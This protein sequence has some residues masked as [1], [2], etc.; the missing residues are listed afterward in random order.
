MGGRAAIYARFSSHNQRGESIEI[1]VE[2]SRAYCAENDLRVVATYCDFAQTGTNTDRAEFQRMMA[3]AKRG[4]FDFV[5]IYKV[6][7]IMR[8]RDEMAMARIMLRRCRVEILYAGED[9]SDGSAGVL[10]LGMLE[11]LAEYESALDGERIRDGIQKNA[12]RCMANGCVRYGWDI[13][14]GRYVV[15]EEE[16]AA[17]RLGVRMVLSG[18]S[19]ADVV[20]AWEPYRTK[21]GGKWRFQTVRRILMRR[22]NGGEYR[23]AGVVVPGGMPAIVPMD[24]EERVIRMLEDSHRPRAKTEAWD[25]PLTG[26]LYDGRDGGLMTGTSGTGKSGR[27]YHYYRCRSCGR[28][29]RGRRRARGPGQRRQPRAHRSHAGRR[30]GGARRREALERDHKGRAGQDRDGVLQHMGGHRVGHRAA[31]RQGAHRR[32]EA[33]AGA[34][35]G[36]AAHGRG[37]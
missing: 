18:K 13:V 5:V 27:P 33:A 29:A 4:L 34:P 6:T 35:Q 10:Q 14:D 15:N 20:R 30:R 36:R 26:K 12:E 2:K 19:V 1:Q 17:I 31:G 8:N 23:Y 32:A 16:A 9:I 11:V 25:F 7:R 24:D 21:R 28:T 22:E 3:D 37:P